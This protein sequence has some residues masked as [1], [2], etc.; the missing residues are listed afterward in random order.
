MIKRIVMSTQ[1]ISG[2][3]WTSVTYPLYHIN[4]KKK[5]SKNFNCERSLRYFEGF[6]IVQKNTFVIQLPKKAYTRATKLV[7]KKLARLYGGAKDGNKMKKLYSLTEREESAISTIV[8][9]GSTDSIM[10][11]IE[12]AVDDGVNTYKQLT[13]DGRCLPGAGATEIELAM[14]LATYAEVRSWVYFPVGKHCS[15]G[16]A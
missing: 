4:Q 3:T 14:Q 7:K 10:D 12:R 11:D 2:F 6:S 15:L 13:R 9:R 16:V 5:I 8:V 1:I